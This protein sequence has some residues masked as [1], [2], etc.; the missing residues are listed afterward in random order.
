[1]AAE[2]KWH[3][4]SA[5]HAFVH[6]RFSEISPYLVFCSWFSMFHCSEIQLL[7]L[8][9]VQLYYPRRQKCLCEW[10]FVYSTEL[11]P[12]ADKNFGIH[13]W[14]PRLARVFLEYTASADRRWISWGSYAI[15][16]IYALLPSCIFYD[17]KLYWL[18]WYFSILVTMQ[19]VYRLCL[20]YYSQCA[21]G[22][23]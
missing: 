1:M 5:S 17:W 3:C 14:G 20:T 19:S 4:F 13:L 22:C 9:S 15:T 16:C 6:Y 23:M 8:C 2:L 7:V 11:C 12:P 10:W 21:I 18:F